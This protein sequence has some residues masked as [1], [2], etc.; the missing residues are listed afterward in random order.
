MKALGI[1]GSMKKAGNANLLVDDKK[2]TD[3][4]ETIKKS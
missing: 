1:V 3:L 4:Y 2:S